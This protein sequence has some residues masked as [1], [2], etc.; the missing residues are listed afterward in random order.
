[1][2]GYVSL[3]GFMLTIPAANWLIGNVGAK[4]IPDGPC[5]I[6][7]GFG[8]E[9]PSGVLMIGLALVLRDAVQEKLGWR[10]TLAAIIAGGALSGFVAPAAFVVASIVAFTVSEL[11]DMAVYTPLRKKRLW[12]AVLASGVAGA[13][14]DSVL[15][16]S[17]A[18]GHLDYVAGNTLGKIWISLA[19]VP[20]LLAWRH[21][22]GKSQ[23]GDA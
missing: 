15:F 5:L 6:P 13:F 12:L 18:L 8:L 7:V 2:I 22:S 16:L 1:M 20:A 19:V 4:C 9:C 10:W 11:A 17:L 14:V 21:L 3:I 23:G